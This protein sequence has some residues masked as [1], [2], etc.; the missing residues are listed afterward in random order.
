MDLTA[1]YQAAFDEA[2]A[3]AKQLV[4]RGSLRA[5][6]AEYAR[7]AQLMRLLAESARSV[8]VRQQRLSRA[9]DLDGMATRL[10]EGGRIVPTSSA[11]AVEVPQD[12]VN[13]LTD[14]IRGLVKEA[15][16]S[17]ADIAGLD[18]AKSEIRSLFA[19]A[20][21]TKPEGVH[22]DERP[23]ILLY[24]PPGTGKT[25]LAAAASKGLDATFYSV[26]AGDLLSRYFGDS[27]RLVG[28][29]YEEADR[30]APSVVFIDEIE[31]LTPDRDSPGGVSGAEGRV[32]AQFLAELD[33]LESKGGEELV[34]TIAATNK[35]WMLDDAVLSRFA[36]LIYID[37]PNEAAREGMF[38]LNIEG[39]GMSSAVT[40]RE[41]AKRSDGL[42]GREIAAICREAVRAM[43]VR[44]N[45]DMDA[46]V[47]KG[48]QA[49]K[50]YELRM[51]HLAEQEFAR[52]FER[53]RP[54]TSA[55]VLA[56]YERWVGER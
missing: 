23:N 1:G 28:K 42:S 7:S 34:I 52:A 41:L 43:L 22:L 31:A 54:A 9:E 18:D 2:Q 39:A 50:E 14:R 32:L 21:A 24:G 49:I 8:P 45:P 11:G 40:L 29:L 55:R 17:W 15:K 36:R 25:L 53:V 56:E 4:D 5:A 38:R 13:E 16:V 19:I 47:D 30:T 48:A 51:V 20:L 46:Q 35:P 26:K 37:L 12:D 44:A 27:P 3:K 6:A 33:G 10:K